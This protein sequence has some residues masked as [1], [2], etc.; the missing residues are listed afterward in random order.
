VVVSS[1]AARIRAEYREMPGLRLTLAQA[2]R[3]WHM[4]PRAC[5]SILM[6]LVAE[7]SLRLTP[8]G[9]FV[10]PRTG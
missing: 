7:G 4:D 6:A 5:E 10:S 9:V 1:E 8:D 3:F 2:A